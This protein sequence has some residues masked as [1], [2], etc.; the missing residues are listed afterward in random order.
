M[1]INAA[2]D[3]SSHQDPNHIISAEHKRLVRDYIRTLAEQAGAN[4]AEALSKQLNLL[5]EGAIVDAHI[6]GNSE[7]ALMAKAM[8]SVFIEKALV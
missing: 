3:F 8:A 1:F 5:L 4:D 2:A 7:A 6:S